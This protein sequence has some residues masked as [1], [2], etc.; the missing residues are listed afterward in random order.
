MKSLFEIPEL[1][2]YHDVGDDG[3]KHLQSGKEAMKDRHFFNGRKVR[4][5]V[6]DLQVYGEKSAGGDFGRFRHQ[7][8]VD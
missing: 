5:I 8:E 7:L 6:K 4:Y 3:G 2:Q 1:E